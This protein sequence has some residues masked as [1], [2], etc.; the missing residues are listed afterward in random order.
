MSGLCSALLLYRINLVFHLIV[1]D[2]KIIV[3]LINLLKFYNN[4]NN[5]LMVKLSFQLFEI[6]SRL[7]HKSHSMKFGCVGPAPLVLVANS[8]FSGIHP[9]FT[10]KFNGDKTLS[11]VG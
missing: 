1:K 9:R 10:W 8:L 3:K 6:S 11:T 2:L 5:L 7:S 4:F